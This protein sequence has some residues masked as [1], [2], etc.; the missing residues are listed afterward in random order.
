M[1]LVT[2]KLELLQQLLL[3]E[4]EATLD[5]IQGLL[6]NNHSFVL[7]DEQ[8]EALDAQEE[9]YKRGEGTF[10]P[11]DEVLDRIAGKARKAS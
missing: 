4:D 9:R 11:L 8:K 7:S 5:H 10:S 3:V 2:K 1:S 6:N